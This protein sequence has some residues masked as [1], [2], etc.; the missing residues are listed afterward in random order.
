MECPGHAIIAHFP[1]IGGGWN[2]TKILVQID[3]RDAEPIS[4]ANSIVYSNNRAETFLREGRIAQVLIDLHRIRRGVVRKGATIDILV[5]ILG[6][7]R[8]GRDGKN[9]EYEQKYDKP[10]VLQHISISV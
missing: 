9:K 2:Q 6:E 3:Q 10:V 5:V 8:R 1:A 4:P 7:Q